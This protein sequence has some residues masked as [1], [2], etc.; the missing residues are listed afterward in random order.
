[1][2]HTSVTFSF[3]SESVLYHGLPD[4]GWKVTADH[5]VAPCY[6]SSCWVAVLYME[7]SLLTVRVEYSLV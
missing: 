4:V 2:R 1:M 7:K 5:K 6:C 3:K